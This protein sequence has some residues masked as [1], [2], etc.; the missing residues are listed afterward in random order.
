MNSEGRKSDGWSSSPAAAMAGR[1]RASA[2]STR[3]ATTLVFAPSWPETT[4][5]RPRAPSTPPSPKRVSAAKV[6][7][8]RSPRR[9][10]APS[11][12]RTTVAASSSG[13]ETWP[14]VRTVSR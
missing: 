1:S 12:S 11:R 2:A 6:T 8:P 4:I 9:R 3:P 10:T 13:V 14:S 7:R 5:T